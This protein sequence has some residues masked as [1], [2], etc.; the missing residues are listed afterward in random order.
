MQNRNRFIDMENK[1]G[2]TKVG[3]GKLGVWDEE[4]EIT[5]NTISNKDILY[6]RGKGSH[7]LAITFNGV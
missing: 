4:I 6:S 1:P 5:I 2:V 7:Y 3:S